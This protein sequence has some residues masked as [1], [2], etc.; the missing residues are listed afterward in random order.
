MG[1]IDVNPIYIDGLSFTIYN[2]DSFDWTDTLLEVNGDYEIKHQIIKS[3]QSLTLHAQN[4]SEGDGK[5]FN[6]YTHKVKDFWIWADT[7]HG[8]LSYLGEYNK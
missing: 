8:K 4:F 2:E 7:P 3:H 5:R 1:F 6:V